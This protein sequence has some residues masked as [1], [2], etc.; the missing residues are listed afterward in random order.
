MLDDEALLQKL[1]TEGLQLASV[2]RRAFAMFIDELIVSLLFFFIIKDQMAALTTPEAVVAYTQ[3][4]MVYV[5]IIKVLYQ[6]LFV[7]MYGATLG[8]MAMKI[9]I[10]DQ[11]YLDIPS[12]GASTI[13]A[14][15]R[16]VSEL[17]FYFGFVVAL[18][19]PLKLTWHD[20]FARTLVVD[21]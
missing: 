3:S 4:L 21:A 18:F 6:A 10:V 1:H 5:L 20:R 13:R 16:V 14:V 11:E 17:L 19:S 7:G 9:K 8:K 15:M 2:N 12:W